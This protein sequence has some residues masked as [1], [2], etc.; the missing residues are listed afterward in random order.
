MHTLLFL[1]SND[2]LRLGECQNT[3]RSLIELQDIEN[4]TGFPRKRNKK[5]EMAY[6]LLLIG[7][8]LDKEKPPGEIIDKVETCVLGFNK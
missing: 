3:L 8:G 6:N 7:S 5:L 2:D 1:Q 4:I